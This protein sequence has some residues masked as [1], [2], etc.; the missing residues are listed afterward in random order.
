MKEFHVDS[1][2]RDA[3]IKEIME[4]GEVT[5]P[6]I[7]FKNAKGERFEVGLNIIAQKDEN[8]KI[9]SYQGIVHNITEAIGKRNLRQ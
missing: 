4:K 3:L 5:R 9:V 8:G 6:R 2:A 7:M 1:D